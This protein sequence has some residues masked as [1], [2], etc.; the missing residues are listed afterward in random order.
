MRQIV[1]KF[2]NTDKSIIGRKFPGGPFFF[3]GFSRSQTLVRE[4][5]SRVLTSHQIWLRQST[6]LS[7]G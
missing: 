1:S 7:L 4:T 2:L 5:R 3:P 6:T